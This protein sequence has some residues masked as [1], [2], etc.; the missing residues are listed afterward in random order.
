[1]H[2]TAHDLERCQYAITSRVDNATLMGV[3]VPPELS[4]DASGVATVP[5]ESAAITRDEPTASAARMAVSRGAVV[6]KQMPS[7]VALRLAVATPA[8]GGVSCEV[9]T[10]FEAC[11]P[12]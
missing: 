4:R 8:S 5:C 3:N 9:S 11:M 12:V 6:I 1:L 10:G 2:G 7:L